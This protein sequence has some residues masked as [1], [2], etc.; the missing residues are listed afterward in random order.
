MSLAPS[1]RRPRLLRY[2]HEL[3]P[4]IADIGDGV[5]HD[6]V[7]LGLDRQLHVVADDARALAAGG[8]RTGIRVG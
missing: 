5:R 7:M 4:V 3:C 2:R 1:D 8:H 6:Q